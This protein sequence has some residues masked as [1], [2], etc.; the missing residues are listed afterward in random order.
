MKMIKLLLISILVNLAYNNNLK[1]EGDKKDEIEKLEGRFKD[2]E[3]TIALNKPITIENNTTQEKYFFFSYD[4]TPDKLN[5]GALILTLSPKEEQIC[6]LYYDY[7]KC[8][9]R[10]DYKQMPDAKQNCNI[11]KGARGIRNTITIVL[12]EDKKIYYGIDCERG[13]ATL[14]L[15]FDGIKSI[16]AER[17]EKPKL[18]GYTYSFY[19]FKSPAELGFAKIKASVNGITTRSKI[20]YDALGCRKTT[21]TTVPL[22]DDA[23]LKTDWSSVGT[24]NHLLAPIYGEKDNYFSLFLDNDNEPSISYKFIAIQSIANNTFEQVV[25][26]E[27][28]LT[29]P[30]KFSAPSRGTIK[31]KVKLN[32]PLNTCFV[33]IDYVGCRNRGELDPLPYK[34][35]Y[36]ISNTEKAK[37]GDICTREFEI[38]SEKVIYF[39]IESRKTEVMSMEFSFTP[40]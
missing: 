15:K 12:K 39:G 6:T 27:Q 8:S 10:T 9:G 4:S 1:I 36:C 13:T 28:N 32:D 22:A 18:M 26:F 7:Y 5:Q 3:H 37:Q 31:I 24:E 40:K 11:S 23:C 19:S 2:G 17:V 16:I 34:E 14:T 21:T 29:V 25:R 35:N 30:F 38:S 20:Y 33:Y